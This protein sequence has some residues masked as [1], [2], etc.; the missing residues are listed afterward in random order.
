MK[1]YMLFS[2]VGGQKIQCV[3]KTLLDEF[4]GNQRGIYTGRAIINTI[5]AQLKPERPIHSH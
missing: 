4:K 5:A 3:F 1:N 2:M